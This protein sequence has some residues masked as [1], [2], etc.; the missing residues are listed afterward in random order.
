LTEDPSELISQLNSRAKELLEANRP[1]LRALEIET[2]A[3]ANGAE[4]WDFGKH[5]AKV[6]PGVLLANVCMGDVGFAQT[7][8]GRH[9]DP[10]FANWVE[11]KTI[12]PLEACM[13]AQY[14]GW[15]L[16]V[17]DWFAMCSGPA[18]LVRGKEKV[19]EQYGLSAPA[20]SVVAVLETSKLPD[21]SVADAVASECN[22][23]PR[24]VQ[25]CVAPTSSRAG[26][27]Q[28]V[29]RSVE[30]AIHKLHE[31]EFDLSC[32]KQGFGAAPIPPQAKNDLIAL[33]WTNDSILYGAEVVLTVDCDDSQIEDIGPRVPSSSSADFG[34]PFLDIFNR[35]EK[36]FYKIDKM[37][38]SPAKISFQNSRT[39]NRF[40]FGG[41]RFD[42]LQAS[43]EE[44]SGN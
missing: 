26:T 28:I 8:S 5:N 31:L 36:D 16:S 9:P 13:A 27:I 3:L 42:I 4:I 12:F 38:F 10:L 40:E 39:G 18:R 30:T 25:L 21:E 35:F 17:G 6:D 19:L 33:G 14:A 32:I 24:H 1:N 23:A 34:T 2:I 22:V 7:T 11:V 20:V 15:P 43:W 29:A 37:L 41:Q 44:V